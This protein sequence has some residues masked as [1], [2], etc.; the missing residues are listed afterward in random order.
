MQD[1][2]IDRAAW[3]LVALTLVLAPAAAVAEANPDEEFEAGNWG[4]Q[5]SVGANLLQSYYTNN[6]NGGDKGSIVWNATLEALAKKQLSDVWHWHN[7]LS[8]AFGQNHQQER[9]AD[10]SLSWQRPDKTTDEIKAESLLRYTRSE[11]APFFSVGFESQFLDQTDA[12]GRDLSLNPLIFSQSVGISRMLVENEER[13]L[14]ARLGFTVHESVRDIYLS[15]PPD[16]ETSSE[17]A[18]DGGIELVLDYDAKLLGGRVE[19]ESEIRVYQPVFYSGKSDVEDLA[20]QVLLD[21][22]LDEDLADYFLATDIDFSNT[23]KANITSVINVQLHLRWVYDKYDNTVVP[24]VED[25]GVTNPGAVAAA[26]RKVGQF[27][28]TMSLGLGYTF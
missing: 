13:T 14:L 2:N 28:Q 22:G 8:L 16:D 20:A 18:V 9:D 27:K 21:A 1:W 12:F 23:F 5:M 25:G 7:T 17:S 26:V 15:A 10:G 19:Y 6:W 24:V 3:A 4:T 11:W